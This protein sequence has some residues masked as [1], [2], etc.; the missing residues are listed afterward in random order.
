M[1]DAGKIIGGLI[2]FLALIT[3][4]IW[5]NMASGKADFVPQLK[6][7]TSEKQCVMPTEYMKTRHMDLLNTWRTEV[8]RNGNRIFTSPDGREYNMSLTNTCMDC[9]SNK[10]DFCDQCH[11]YSAVG[12]PNCWDCHNVPG[13]VK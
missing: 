10:A 13:E 6:Y 9:H 2:I 5:Y 7:V 4:P 3:S 1:Y 12:Q 8:V 11:N